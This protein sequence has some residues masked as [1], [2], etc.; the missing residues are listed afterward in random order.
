[1][2]RQYVRVKLMLDENSFWEKLYGVEL[3]INMIVK[4]VNL[5]WFGKIAAFMFG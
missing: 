4:F 3:T 1:M 2:I 5:S